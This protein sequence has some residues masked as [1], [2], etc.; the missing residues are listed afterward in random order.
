LNEQSKILICTNKNI[1]AG[2]VG[3]ST[4]LASNRNSKKSSLNIDLLQSHQG[5]WH[6]EKQKILKNATNT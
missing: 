1:S 6:G 3:A 5:V 4:S 2:S